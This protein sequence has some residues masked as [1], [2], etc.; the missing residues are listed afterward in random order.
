MGRA[1]SNTD[2]E[3]IMGVR[4]G[5]VG[6]QK[7]SAVRLQQRSSSAVAMAVVIEKLRCGLGYG[8]KELRVIWGD[9]T[10]FRPKDRAKF[11]LRLVEDSVYG[12]NSYVDFLCKLHAKIQA[13]G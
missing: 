3:L 6:R 7:P 10:S 8:P 2:L 13:K 9:D 5:T 4:A 12:V 11:A 1:V